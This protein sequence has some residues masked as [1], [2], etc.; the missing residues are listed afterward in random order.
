[1]KFENVALPQSLHTSCRKQ[2]TRLDY[3]SYRNQSDLPSTY[4]AESKTLSSCQSPFD[5]RKDFLFCGEEESMTVKLGSKRRKSVTNVETI[6]FLENILK[7][8]TERNDEFGQTVSTRVQSYIDLIAVEA[9]YH[10]ECRRRF[11]LHDVHEVSGKRSREGPED[12]SKAP[13]LLKLCSYLDDIDEC[14][15]SLGELLDL[16]DTY[17][18]GQKG[19]TTKDLQSKLSEHYGDKITVTSIPGKPN[20]VCFR[21]VGHAILH[22]K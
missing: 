18:D 21:D 22:E 12:K 15:Y 3:K 1:M 20:V 13:A 4:T 5:F 9:I 19:Y 10:R 6:E 7:R 14:Q 17:L 11:F 8:T 16:M 2:Y